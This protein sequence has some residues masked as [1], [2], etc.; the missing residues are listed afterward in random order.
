MVEFNHVLSICA[1]RLHIQN[2]FT[3]FAVL[4]VS[5]NYSLVSLCLII[6][7]ISASYLN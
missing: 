1:V 6:I 4:A 7:C 2:I 3:H 5:I